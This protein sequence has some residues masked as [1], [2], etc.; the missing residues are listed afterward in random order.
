MNNNV[1]GLCTAD[2]QL[3]TSAQLRTRNLVS[4]P[5]HWKLRAQQTEKNT[6]AFTALHPAAAAALAAAPTVYVV[7]PACRTDLFGLAWRGVSI[8]TLTYSLT[9]GQNSAFNSELRHDR[10]CEGEKRR[11]RDRQKARSGARTISG[12]PI[13]GVYLWMPSGWRWK[14]PE[15]NIVAWPGDHPLRLI[16]VIDWLCTPVP[17]LQMPTDRRL[18]TRGRHL[19]FFLAF[20]NFVKS[21]ESLATSESPARWCVCSM[22]EKVEFETKC[23]TADWWGSLR[24]I[25][26]FGWQGRTECRSLYYSLKVFSTS[27]TCLST[28]IFA[29]FI[30]T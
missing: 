8:V 15:Y 25:R 24:C 19:R 3:L 29:S 18:D 11:L 23:K 16:I 1:V 10:W 9:P 13:A 2:T 22:I 7:L 14:P 21:F 4:L 28:N 20:I 6:T 26:N 27:I 12:C 5:I 30:A 17:T